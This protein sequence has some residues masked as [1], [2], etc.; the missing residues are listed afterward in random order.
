V[1]GTRGAGGETVRGDWSDH[2]TDPWWD[3]MSHS[4]QK[5][6]ASG[7][8]GTGKKDQPKDF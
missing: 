8:I 5:G 7:N 3:L 2:Q 6:E 4:L 1:G